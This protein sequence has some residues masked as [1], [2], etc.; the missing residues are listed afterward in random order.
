MS[1]SC[2]EEEVMSHLSLSHKPFTSSPSTCTIVTD[3][4]FV[5][6][7]I[8]GVHTLDHVFLKV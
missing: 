1:E 2:K 5:L 4:T 8:S 3:V 7:S 6:L